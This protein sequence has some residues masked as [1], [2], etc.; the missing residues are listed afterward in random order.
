M[1]GLHAGRRVRGAL[2]F[3]SFLWARKERNSSY[4]G[5]TPIKNKQ[6]LLRAGFALEQRLHRLLR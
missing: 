3:G 5:E 1:W 6:Q 4:G 2:S